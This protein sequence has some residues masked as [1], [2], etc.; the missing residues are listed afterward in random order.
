MYPHLASSACGEAALL[1][2]V[3]AGAALCF[4]TRRILKVDPI[5][6]LGAD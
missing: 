4:A 2:L 3:A 6:T 1:V 5:R